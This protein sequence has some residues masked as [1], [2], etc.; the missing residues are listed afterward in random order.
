MAFQLVEGKSYTIKVNVTNRSTKVGQPWEARLRVV[1]SAAVDSV[2]LLS[3]Q[4][5]SYDFAPGE[6]HSFDFPI[7][8]PVNTGG[9]SGA[10]AVEVLDPLGSVIASGSDII[11]IASLPAGQITLSYENMKIMD[12][13]DRNS[14]SI[15]YYNPETKQWSGFLFP[16]YL[17][18][19]YSLQVPGTIIVQ[20]KEAQNKFF[21][22]YVYGPYALT[23]LGS[24]PYIWDAKNEKL[25]GQKFNNLAMLESK[26]LVKGTVVNYNDNLNSVHVKVENSRSI[27]GLNIGSYFIGGVIEIKINLPAKDLM[28]VTADF[29]IVMMAIGTNYGQD[30]LFFLIRDIEFP[31]GY[32][33]DFYK[34]TIKAYTKTLENRAPWCKDDPALGWTGDLDILCS[35]S[36]PGCVESTIESLR[37][38]MGINMSFVLRKYEPASGK[39][40]YL[41]R[42]PY[43]EWITYHLAG[44]TVP[45]N[46]VTSQAGELWVI[47]FKHDWPG[48]GQ[49]E[50]QGWRRR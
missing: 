19:F 7:N 10:I 45:P 27:S 33:D 38:T 43:M 14:W 22:D 5:R 50:A 2:V 48:I 9:K 18:E 31:Y 25:N 42:Y 44:D 4:E 46:F 17:N 37:S 23:G 3:S 39:S 26:Y 20:F 11:Q 29:P 30:F 21:N 1:T 41:Y 49:A 15:N 36:Q 13:K 40:V 12:G 28:G 8:V 24:G 32:P 34:S 16:N 47:P 6:A 35:A